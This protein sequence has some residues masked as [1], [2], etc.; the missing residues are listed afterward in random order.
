MTYKPE[1]FSKLTLSEFKKKLEEYGC[2]LTP[3]G[4]VP[5][6]SRFIIRAQRGFNPTRVF[7][8]DDGINDGPVLQDCIVNAC[9]ELE[10]V[11]ANFSAA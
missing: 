5:G 2:F 9:K 8:F 1:L 11:P 10:L 4:A 7:F 6:T 3:E